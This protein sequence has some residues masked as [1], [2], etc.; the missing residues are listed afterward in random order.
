MNY[1]QQEALKT[2]LKEFCA[3]LGLPALGITSWPLPEEAQ[4]HLFEETPCPFTEEDIN[5]RLSGNTQL[6]N[7]RSAIV[8]LFS[9]YVDSTTS[10]EQARGSTISS[11]D[12]SSLPLSS[13][14][15]APHSKGTKPF[16]EA[17]LARY[18]WG[19]DYHLVVP[20]YLNT[21]Q[22]FLQKALAQ[23]GEPK[24]N[25]EIHCDTSPL[26]DRY[27]AYLSGLGFY[28]K[29]HCFINPILG[30]YVVIGTILT[31]LVL[32]P[33]NPLNQSC[34]GCNKCIAA[35]PGQALGSGKLLFSQC[36]SYLTQ[37]KGALTEEEETILAK[38]PLL[39]G[40]DICQEVCPH[41]AKVPLTTIKEFQAIEPHVKVEELT[42]LTNKEF[43]ARYGERAFSWRGKAILLRNA[44]IIEKG[45][46]S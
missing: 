27:M 1:R 6:E 46:P 40:C 21:I 5:K 39:F 37:K 44:Q 3:S 16:L 10:D 28:G 25:F 38:T 45:K 12:E 9:Y 19:K 34:F 41:N 22:D 14:E 18:T 20:A 2:E 36:K 31:D 26:A 29:N 13:K 33:D 42:Q 4:H 32:P 7:P 11:D 43:K 35:C 23:L 24:A 15:A 8:L 30:S 17:N